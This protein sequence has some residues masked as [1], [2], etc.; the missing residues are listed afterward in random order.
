MTA[1]KAQIVIIGGGGA[2]LA[3]AVEAVERGASDII[4]IEKR[5]ALGGNS[6]LAG[7]LFACESPVQIRQRIMADKDYLFKKAMD[8]AHWCTSPALLRAF[9]NKSG[10]TIKWLEE[11]GLEF[12]LIHFYPNQQPPVQHNPRGNGA[13]L[14]Q[15]LAG[16]CRQ[17]G[18]QIFLQAEA[19]KIQR[20]KEGKVAG[21]LAVKEGQEI[22]IKAGS[23]LVTTGGFAGNSELMDRYFP[24]HRGLAHS[25]L[26]LH[27]DGI[28]L[29]AGTGAA[30][31]NSATL[32]KEGPRYDLHRWPLMALERDPATLWVNKNG[33]R[34]TDESTGYHIFECANAVMRQ[35]EKL[36]FTLLD[37]RVRRYFEREGLKLVRRSGGDEAGSV[38]AELEK[39][40]HEG[41]KADKVRIS[42]SWDDIADWIGAEKNVLKNTVARYNSSCRRGYDAL[43]AKERKYLLPLNIA[44]Y[45][46]I[47]DL[48]VVLDT[49]GGIRINERMEVLDPRNIPIPGLYAA[50]VVTSGWE[51]EIYCSELSASAFGF[52]VNSGRIAGENAV[53]YN[54]RAG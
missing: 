3:A 43:F 20:D 4:V 1:V 31:E 28:A 13:H 45:Y 51:P 19:I 16:Q 46:A 37:T 48:T 44:P 26:P 23:V 36:C 25:G 35:P 11:K 5:A 21:V 22:E 29:A 12:D 15:V 30:I 40:F 9:I 24:H 41:M 53:S 42:G 39:A 27:G 38:R 33:E 17:S 8:W 7:G 47:K 49:I 34:F 6:A 32:L 54:R 50:G 14:I 18:V 52:A 2:G 10:D